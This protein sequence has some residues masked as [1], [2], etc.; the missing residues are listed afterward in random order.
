M[1]LWTLGVSELVVRK[2]LPSNHSN[3][4]I[5]QL[6]GVNLAPVTLLPLLE[7]SLPSRKYRYVC[8]FLF[9]YRQDISNKYLADNN[10][11][12]KFHF[13]ATI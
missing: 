10:R 11:P 5:L 3:N 4:S 9:V 6:N 2:R 12:W 7:N 13:L 1:V 8:A